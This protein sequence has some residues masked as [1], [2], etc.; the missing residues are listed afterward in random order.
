MKSMIG[1]RVK[2]IVFGQHLLNTLGQV[3]S[4]GEAG[5]KVI[6][7]W[8]AEKRQHTPK[9]CKY[10]SQ[11]IPVKTIDEGLSVVFGLK[12]CDV[13]HFLS[14]DSD[15]FVSLLDRHYDELKDFFYFFNAGEKGRLSM[16]MP[17]LTQCEIAEKYGIKSP[18]SELVKW[19]QLPSKLGYPLFTKASDCFDVRWKE[20]ASICYSQEDLI[21]LYKKSNKKELLLQEYIDRDNEIALQGLSINGGNVLY[22]PIQGEYKS[23]PQ[24][25]FGSIKE[26]RG[27][28]LGDEL[29]TKIKKM[30]M[31][32][33]YSG[34]FEIEFLKDNE[35]ELYFLEINFRQTQY[36]HALT[37]MGVN[38]SQLWIEANCCDNRIGSII[39]NKKNFKKS[40][41]IN[42]IRDFDYF[43]RTGDKSV[44]QWLL[45]IVRA[46]SHY[47]LDR[48]DWR[49]CVSFFCNSVKF[50]LFT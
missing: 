14:T 27:Y 39:Q 43:V 18:H 21:N 16:F 17:K 34:I 9:G 38:L 45:D 37:S 12:S 29:E 44:G 23:L 28:V 47:L 4:F 25:A 41:V 31:E 11:Y 35:N 30:F 42:E 26:N 7:I 22:L 50:K 33:G 5:H 8:L 24:G 36:N 10:I 32:I 46:D 49:Y 15:A 1:N 19:G 6:V 48:K 13:K 40:I 2:I 20:E 3:R